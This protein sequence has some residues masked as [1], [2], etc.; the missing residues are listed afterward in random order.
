LGLAAAFGGRRAQPGEAGRPDPTATIFTAMEE[1][2]GLKLV[3]SHTSREF[4]VIDHV[5]RPAAGQPAQAPA[6][7][8]G[9]G[10]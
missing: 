9:A 5:E 1:Q 2:L 8:R 7:A 4:I 10:R 6:R 3:P